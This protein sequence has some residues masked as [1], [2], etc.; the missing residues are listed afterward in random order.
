MLFYIAWVLIIMK[1]VL[2]GDSI[3]AIMLGRLGMTVEAC[4]QAYRAMAQEAF[5]P[6]RSAILPAAPTGAYSATAL[7]GAIKRVVREHCDDPSCITRRQS[8]PT[9]STV[10][11]CPHGEMLF[12]H[13][14]CTKT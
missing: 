11:A 3:I 4:I 1:N 6:K 7:E 12:R 5:T 14:G 2:K 13:A 8:H 10:N 9:G